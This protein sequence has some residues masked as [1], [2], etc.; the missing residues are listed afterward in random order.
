M[1]PTSPIARRTFLR[2]L[3]TAMALPWLPSALPKAAWAAGARAAV[4][5][6][7]LGF[8]YIPNGAHMQAWTPE[9]EGAGFAL[10]ATL[11]PL[12]PFRDKLLVLS[13]LTADKARAN[14]DGAGDHARS[15]AAFLTGTQAEKT[16][17]KG[18]L[19]TP[20]IGADGLIANP[21]DLSAGAARD[22]NLLRLI[23]TTEG[24]LG[25]SALLAE[26]FGRYDATTV[27]S[28]AFHATIDRFSHD[29]LPMRAATTVCR[30]NSG[31]QFNAAP[32]RIAA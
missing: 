9:T 26:A 28:A 21:A 25:Q 7:R 1:N 3:G 22:G 23:G 11:E 4:P 15:A 6:L 27:W 14:G 13:G 30:P 16:D 2:G 32:S 31:G 18:I 19:P 29:R 8:F 12:A 24:H 17:G 5:P 10:P 20:T